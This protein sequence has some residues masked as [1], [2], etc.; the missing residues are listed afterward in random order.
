LTDLAGEDGGGGD[1]DNEM[2][3]LRDL[4]QRKKFWMVE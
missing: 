3:G 4:T 1:D 2:Y